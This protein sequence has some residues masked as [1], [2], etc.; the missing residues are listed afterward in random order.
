MNIY[1]LFQLIYFT[2]KELAMFN[3]LLMF[4][5]IIYMYEQIWKL[6]KDALILEITQYGKTRSYYYDWQYFKGANYHV[7]VPI[8]IT[9]FRILL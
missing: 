9:F 5:V 6:M 1:L 2:V 3:S 7:I 4:S 8:L